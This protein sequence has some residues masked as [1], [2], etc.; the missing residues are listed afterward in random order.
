MYRIE[1]IFLK[2]SIK[3]PLKTVGQGKIFSGNISKVAGTNL[4]RDC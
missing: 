1:L 2:T 3:D 4:G